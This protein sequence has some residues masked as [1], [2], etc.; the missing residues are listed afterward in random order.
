MLDF[1]RISGK[2]VN[3]PNK[4]D[5]IKTSLI[6]R[7]KVGENKSVNVSNEKDSKISRADETK[8]IKTKINKPITKEHTDKNK[9]TKNLIKPKKEA[10]IKETPTDTTKEFKKKKHVKN[11]D[12]KIVKDDQ[13]INLKAE[14]PVVAESVTIVPTIIKATVDNAIK[15]QPSIKLL[16]PHVLQAKEDLAYL[17]KT[18][19]ELLLPIKWSR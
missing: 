18:F 15:E 13:P 1:K 19:A 6:E 5:L 7:F 9:A 10:L 2:R 8:K 4:K 16:P 11:K 3:I 17:K 14:S 12:I